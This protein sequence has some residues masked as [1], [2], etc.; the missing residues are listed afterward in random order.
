MIGDGQ[1]SVGSVSVKP[2]VRK[3]RRIGEG[4]VAG[5]AGEGPPEPRTA[6]SSR[7]L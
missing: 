6:V 7:V 1:V 3:V 5:F 4:V 2:N